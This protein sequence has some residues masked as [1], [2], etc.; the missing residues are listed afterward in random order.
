MTDAVARALRDRFRIPASTTAESAREIP[1]GPRGYFRWEGL[2]LYGRNLHGRVGE[3]PG[4]AASDT[5]SSSGEM[6]F[7]PEEII[8]DLRLENY[9]PRLGQGDRGGARELVRKAYYL[10]RPL[11]PVAFRKH[12]QRRFLAGRLDRPFPAWPVDTTVETLLEKL[13]AGWMAREDVETLPFLWFWPDG[14]R[15]CVTMT[16]DVETAIGRDFTPELAALDLAHGFRPAFQFIPE[17]RYDL[18]DSLRAELERLGAEINVHG[19]NHDGRLFFDEELFRRRAPRINEH[20]RR[21]GA[22]GFRSPVLYRNPDWFGQLEFDYEMSLPNVGHLD[23]QPGGCCTVFPYFIGDKV[24]I[25]LTTTQDYTLLHI[26]D[27]YSLDLWRRQL[28]IILERGGL[29]SFNIHP[30][31]VRE[32]RAN[33][34]FRSLLEFLARSAEERRLWVASPGEIADWWRC[35]ATL[36][37]HEEDG[38]WVPRGEGSERAR[39]A[40]ARLGAGGLTWEL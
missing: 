16:H 23:P 28:E 5:T 13:L 21:L 3:T 32:P 38:R 8:D 35:R 6:P 14:Y 37:I 36:E 18:P 30:D 12:L 24:E 31:Y 9:L 4:D 1:D 10:L 34:L 26:F 29:A 25:P 22:R 15:G 7:D 11:F 39:V 27:D 20:G 17:E 2:T 33:A 40:H 19:L